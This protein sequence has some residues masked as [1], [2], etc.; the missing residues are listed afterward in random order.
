MKFNV[1]LDSEYLKQIIE[2]E[3]LS[4]LVTGNAGSGKSMILFYLIIFLLYSGK[5]IYIIDCEGS[6]SIMRHLN[7][8]GFT[9]EQVEQFRNKLFILNVNSYSEI[10]KKLKK[11]R[12][13]KGD[14]FYYVI[15]GITSLIHDVS[16]MDRSGRIQQMNFL[17]GLPPKTIFSANTYN[18]NVNINVSNKMMHI[19]SNVIRVER[20]DDGYYINDVKNRMFNPE[21]I[22]AMYSSIKMLIRKIR[23]ETIINEL[24]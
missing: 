2:Q 6:G 20:K 18:S 23:I 14:D 13:T 4:L 11:N 21:D 15:D 5:S 19:A 22:D 24:K 3:R 7:R 9:Q 8:M 10:N 17:R 1:N 16:G 12:S